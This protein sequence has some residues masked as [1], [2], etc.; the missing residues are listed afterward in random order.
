M[1]SPFWRE[2]TWQRRWPAFPSQLLGATRSLPWYSSGRSLPS[3]HFPRPPSLC[4]AVA[5]FCSGSYDRCCTDSSQAE[6]VRY[7]RP[8]YT[9]C[10]MSPPCLL[11][12]GRKLATICTASSCLPAPKDRS[13][14]AD[15]SVIVRP[16][17][18]R[19]AT[20]TQWRVTGSGWIRHAVTQGAAVAGIAARIIRVSCR[21]RVPVGIQ[22]ALAITSWLLSS[23]ARTRRLYLCQGNTA[24]VSA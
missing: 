12:P 16:C 17:A 4:E 20:C 7:L 13:Y 2:L 11:D 6:K 5:V 1:A 22:A 24:H 14:T 9:S 18:G 8:F 21:R 19:S 10:A 3:P 23:R 15:P